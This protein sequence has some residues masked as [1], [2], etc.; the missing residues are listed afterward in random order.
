M[1][2]TPG[3]VRLIE[4][5]R[6]LWRLRDEALDRPGPGEPDRRAWLRDKLGLYVDALAL[7]ALAECAGVR[8]SDENRLK[9]IRDF[10]RHFGQR[11]GARL[12]PELSR[13][14]PVPDFLADVI[15]RDEESLDEP[16]P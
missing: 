5:A 7:E 8:P 6:A 14:F 9:V 4:Q 2:D 11:A 13:L 16:R 12:V 10:R 3:M 15:A 1:A